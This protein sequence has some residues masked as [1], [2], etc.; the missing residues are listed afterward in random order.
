MQSDGSNLSI[1]SNRYDALSDSWGSAELIE[2]GD[3]DA[4]GPMADFDGSGNATAVWYQSDGSHFSV[5][6]NRYDTLSDSWGSAGLIED[7]A[8]DA[9]ATQVTVEPGGRALAVW[10]QTDSPY[11]NIYA[12]LYE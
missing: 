5:Y 11:V 4:Y 2:S 3:N 8:N 9:F 7:S 1:Y 12:N 6:A 10:Y